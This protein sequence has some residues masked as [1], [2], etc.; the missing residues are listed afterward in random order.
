MLTAEQL[1]ARKGKITSSIAAACLG[2]HPYL[3]PLQAK[4]RILGLD[5]FTGNKA[6]ERGN[7][8]ENAILSYPSELYNLNW[9]HAPFRKHP[10]FI[11]S[12][13][14]CDALYASGESYYRSSIDAIGE[15]KTAALGPAS[16]YGEDGTDDIPMHVLVQCHWHLIHWPEVDLCYVPVLIGGYQF[17]FRCYQV[18]RDV[19][20]EKNLL[21]SLE[22]WHYEYLICD[23]TPPAEAGDIDYIKDKYPSSCEPLEQVK[24]G[25][26]LDSIV[27]DYV[28]YKEET[29]AAKL[30]EDTVRARLQAAIGARDGFE[31]DAWRVTWRSN[32]PSQKIN[33][34]VL[35]NKLLDT[36]CS[37]DEKSLLLRDHAQTIPGARVLRAS[38]KEIGK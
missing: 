27:H 2:L 32:K 24:L 35:A 21:Q 34:E 9:D 3:T 14:S 7:L 28:R 15:G 25:T 31:S 33:Y 10:E 8:L 16:E 12:A 4:A 29:K 30:R 36:K 18:K 13:D 17:Q 22:K 26:E 20:L 38:L 19:E 5:G 6:T 37:E 1:E 23:K 11:W